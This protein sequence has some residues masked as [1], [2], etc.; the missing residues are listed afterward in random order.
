MKI[1]VALSGGGARCLAQ[2]GYLSVLWEMGITFGALSGSSGGSIAAA[3]L[4]LGMSP[5]EAYEAV[6]GFD[7]SAIKLNLF[8]GS[9]FRLDEVAPRFR[10]MGLED[11]EKLS[12]PLSVTLTRYRD[13]QT[14]YKQEGDLATSLIASSALIPIFAPVQL[15][16]ELYIDGAFSDNLPVKPLLHHPYHILAINV[17]PLAPTF[18]PTFMGHFKK[19][20]YTLFSNTIKESI[21]LA[22]TFVQ[23][24]EAG[25][26]G[27]L[28]K[29]HIDLIYRLG[30]EAGKKEE[31]RWE[32]LCLK[33][34]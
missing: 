6:K 15:E 11:F 9:L 13:T 33:N 22:H 27:I 1:A 7:F 31:K 5:K 18:R 16:G 3:F 21:P 19:A 26:F 17:N 10:A 14:I 34:S 12:L 25:K 28:D 29:R 20:C 24:E 30:V 4:A 32:A 23:I 8:R 2:L